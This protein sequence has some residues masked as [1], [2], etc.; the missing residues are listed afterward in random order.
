MFLGSLLLHVISATA[1]LYLSARIVPGVEFFGSYWMLLAT[2]TVLGLANFLAK[3]VLKAVSLPVI[4][5]TLGLFSLVIN[6]ALVWLIADVLFPETFEISGI[7]PLFWTT[8]I[9]WILNFFL[10]FRKNPKI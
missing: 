6:M 5:L 7:I 3:P 2:G 10:V 1:G 9:I 4:L 8:F